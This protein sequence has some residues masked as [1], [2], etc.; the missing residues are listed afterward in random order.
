MLCIRMRHAARAPPPPYFVGRRFGAGVYCSCWRFA[1]RQIAAILRGTSRNSA[2]SVLSLDV[3]QRNVQGQSKRTPNG[4][5]REPKRRIFVWC[6]YL[7]CICDF[8]Q[9]PAAQSATVAWIIASIKFPK[10]FLD[11]ALVLEYWNIFGK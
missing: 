1:K 9:W 4:R 5:S 3:P 2:Y 8:I 11:Y 6:I 10:L 7:I